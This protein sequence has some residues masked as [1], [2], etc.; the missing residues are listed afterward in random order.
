MENLIER[1]IY[2]VTRR[3]PEKERAEVSRELN[4]HIFDMLPDD[5]DEMEIREA[6]NRLGSPSV[7]AGQYRQSPGYLISPVIYGDYIRALKWVTPLIGGIFFALGGALGGIDA[8]KDG[9]V[10]GAKFIAEV[11]SNAISMGISG[12]FYALLWTTVGFVIAERAH[13]EKLYGSDW[14]VDQLP[15]EIPESRGSIPVSD[16]IAELVITVIFSVL[17]VM[18]CLRMFPV[19]I[20][21]S[22]GGI[23]VY[24]IFSN[25][26]MS[27]G[28]PAVIITGILGV[29]ECVAKIAKR[30]W[31]PSV[32][33]TVVV[34]NLVSIGFVLYLVTRSEMF[35]PEFT[36][37]IRAQDWGR[38]KILSFLGNSL[39]E[40]VVA[41]FAVIAIV[42]SLAACGNAIY[43]TVRANRMD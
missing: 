18:L 16:S 35:T 37:F 40:P 26:F 12:A 9:M 11:L 8:I 7:L 15:R 3:I 41:V 23:E 5:P 39:G 29:C 21:I 2:D 19:S 31:T 24:Q 27:A 14:T 38:I 25:S 32:C 22:S 36:A 43:R 42:A 4:A 34:S 30:R 17:L 6:L 20:L 28:T 10:D 13:G 33:G 1:Y